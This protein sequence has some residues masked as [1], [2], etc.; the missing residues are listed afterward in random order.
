[1]H[2]ITEIGLTSRFFQVYHAYHTVYHKNSGTLPLTLFRLGF[3]EL[4]DAGGGVETTHGLYL[5]Y[6]TQ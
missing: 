4:R 5:E 6:Y 1:M 2:Y 3:L